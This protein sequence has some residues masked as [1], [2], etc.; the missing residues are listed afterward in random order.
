[1]SEIRIEN[2]HKSFGAHEVIRD[3]S[4]TIS[5]QEICIFVGPSGCGK[6]TLLRLIAGLEEATSGS[7][8][9]GGKDVTHLEPYDRKLSMVFQSYALYPHMNV[10]DNIAFALHTAKL[11]KDQIA[12]K[13]AEAA[14]ILRLEDYL[15]RRPNALSGGQRLRVAIGRAIVRE[16]AAFLFDEPLSNLDAALRADTRVEIATLHRSLNATSIYVTHDQTEAMTLA[17]RIVV[18]KDGQIMQTGSPTELYD[19]PANV[20]VAQFLGSPKMNILNVQLGENVITIPGHKEIIFP[21]EA[22]PQDV[23]L[24]VR[25]EAISLVDPDQGQFTGVV[26]L[27]EYHGGSRTVVADIGVENLVTVQVPANQSPH[28]G[29][30]IRLKCSIE[31]FH[32]FQTNGQRFLTDSGKFLEAKLSDFDK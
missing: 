4:L 8:M 25:P 26:K 28:I 15:D 3:I 1:M 9:I 17:D 6:S 19:N 31:N 10:R 23:Q 13:V 5:E 20:F 27:N 24:G 7:I 11:P 16:P 2:L 18:L 14:R 12:E 22:M 21:A 29:E 30:K 32:I